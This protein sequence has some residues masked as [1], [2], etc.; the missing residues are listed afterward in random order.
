M[1]DF[2]LA[3]VVGEDALMKTL[4][5]TP[6]Y[7]AAEVI[8]QARGG[9]MS[10]YTNAVDMWALGVILYVML[11]GYPPF[12]P[13][14]FDDILQAKYDFNH[15]RWK[16]VS[17]GAKRLIRNILKREPSERFTVDQCLEDKWLD[18]V[19]IPP[20]PEGVEEDVKP[21]NPTESQAKRV[22][23]QSGGQ[24]AIDGISDDDDDDDNVADSK[25]EGGKQVRFVVQ[26]KE[27][28]KTQV[29]KLQ[30]RTPTGIPKR[31]R[32]DEDDEEDVPEND[33]PKRRSARLR[34]K[35]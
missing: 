24:Q 8:E 9:K 15:S 2:G 17:A 33:K 11:A 7:L 26:G 16:T 10:G 3:R 19:V 31:S 34:K 4:C 27:R 21:T 32:E 29:T 14:D 22:H 30:K 1:G 5:G 13:K 20:L 12:G 18:G 28:A 35:R 23:G 25:K 6:Q